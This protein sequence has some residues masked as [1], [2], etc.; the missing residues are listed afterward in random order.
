MAKYN[1]KGLFEKDSNFKRW[2][3]NIRRGSPASADANLRRIGYVT[4]V[5]NV[6][7]KQLAAMTPKQGFEIIDDVITKLEKEG[8]TG[9]YMRAYVK[10]LKSWF[11]H[12]GIQI[13]QKIKV[14]DDDG[15]SKASREQ[16]PMP[17]QLRRVLNAADQKQKVEC[18]LV[19]F[20]GLRIETLGD[21]ESRDG[22]KV[23][24][25]PEM[26][27]NNGNKTV[28]FTKIPALVII[29]RNL[30]KA[31]HQY[32]TFMPDEECDYVKELFEYRMNSGETITEDSAV[33]VSLRYHKGWLEGKYT[34]K[35]RLYIDKSGHIKTGNISDSMRTT[36]R[37]A[38]FDWR[39]YIMRTY[40]D[41]RM[42][43]AEA[44]GLIIRDWRVF[45]MG[46]K[47][48]MEHRYT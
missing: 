14:P 36:I 32:F 6:T 33:V 24:D 46:H 9:E 25:L 12:N 1:Y 29:R 34:N 2:Y 3:G 20:S 10:A 23:K 13:S 37:K 17:E 4:R 41:T 47:G 38:G 31:G 15:S 28:E 30:S 44:D 26:K 43:M 27:I 19:G 7:T 39:P 42:M 5:F 11:I 40:F 21:Y 45:W 22:L 18:T 8:K 16:S 35:D 48:D